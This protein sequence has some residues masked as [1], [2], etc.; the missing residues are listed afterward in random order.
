[1]STISTY[2]FGKLIFTGGE[3]GYSLAVS[4]SQAHIA[5]LTSEQLAQVNADIAKHKAEHAEQFAKNKKA[6]KTLD[7][8][9]KFA[10]PDCPGST[11]NAV[12]KRI[13][14]DYANAGQ[15]WVCLYFPDEDECDDLETGWFD[16]LLRDDA[17]MDLGVVDVLGA[18]AEHAKKVLMDSTCEA[19]EIVKV[20]EKNDIDIIGWN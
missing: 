17:V 11:D 4:M 16:I 15:S 18:L 12:N 1:M 20:F 5:P 7:N 19:E 9:L 13:P 14:A 8:F 6:L 3:D 2:S 10:L